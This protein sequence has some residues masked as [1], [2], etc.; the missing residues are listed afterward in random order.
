MDAAQSLAKCCPSCGRPFIDVPP[1]FVVATGDVEYRGVVVRLTPSE[2]D[3]FALLHEAHPRPVTISTLLAELY[4]GDDDDIKRNSIIV[5]VARIRQKL[6]RAG[7]KVN[8][9]ARHNRG[10]GTDGEGGGYGLVWGDD[11]QH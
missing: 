9:V 1:T 2:V 10:R 4:P 8:V 5:F 11:V 7:V 3:L 6:R